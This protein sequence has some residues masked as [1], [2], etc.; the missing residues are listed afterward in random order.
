MKYNN[1]VSAMLTKISGEFPDLSDA[2]AAAVLQS[3]ADVLGNG[4]STGV[5]RLR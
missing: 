1:A 2:Q 5:N 4:L 3:Y